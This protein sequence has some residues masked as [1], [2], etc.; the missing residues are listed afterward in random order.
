[1]LR[2]LCVA[3]VVRTSLNLLPIFREQI[4]NSATS[5]VVLLCVE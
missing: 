2:R 4:Y 1:M 3:L 5:E